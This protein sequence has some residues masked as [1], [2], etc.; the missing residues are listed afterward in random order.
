MPYRMVWVD[1]ETDERA[2][3][4]GRLTYAEA[5]RRFGR[6]VTWVH[7]RIGINVLRTVNFAGRT[8]VDENSVAQVL[9]VEGYGPSISERAEELKRSGRGVEAMALL[10]QAQAEA[11]REMAQFGYVSSASPETVTCAADD[12]GRDFVRKYG[13]S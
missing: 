5:A 3:R 12:M 1:D 2:Q 6:S 10:E 13:G 7:S 8:Y 9:R 4:G 11:N